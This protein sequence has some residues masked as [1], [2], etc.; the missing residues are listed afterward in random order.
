[1]FFFRL[2]NIMKK[3]LL[4]AFTLVSSFLFAQQEEHYSMYMMNNYLLNPAE[5]GTEEYIDLKLG[6]RTQWVNLEGSPKSFFLSGHSPIH[7]RTSRFE[8]VKQLP[9]HGVGGVVISD[10]IGVYDRL[11]AKASYSYH[12]P[13]TTKLTVSFG[14]F[15]GIKQFKY[16]DS[17]AEYSRDGTKDNTFNSSLSTITPDISLG[18]WGYSKKYYFGVSSFQLLNNKINWNNPGEAAANPEGHLDRHYF[19]TA[20]YLIPI[21]T[22]YHL[23]PSFVIKAV[24][25]VPVQFDLN[26]KFR[27]QDLAWLGISYRNKD[28]IVA[29]AGITIKKKVDIAYAYDVNTSALNT[30]NKGSHEVLIGLRM[31]YHKHDPP[32]AQFW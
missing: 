17:R 2:K 7:K 29:L 5:G 21:G 20:G 3:G 6:Y 23:V 24:S 32:P 9:F 15:V 4:I 11:T 19:V 10:R 22:D 13:V 25:P 27:Y 8:E 28:A 31:P 18:I 30:Y 16:D 26:A 1:M 14:A 12:L